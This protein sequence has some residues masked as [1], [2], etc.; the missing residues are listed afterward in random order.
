ML[1]FRLILPASVLLED[2]DGPGFVS[3]SAQDNSCSRLDIR[4]YRQRCPCFKYNNMH[5]GVL[6]RPGNWQIVEGRGPE[7]DLWKLKYYRSLRIELP[8]KSYT[9]P[10]DPKNCPLT[11]ETA[12]ICTSKNKKGSETN[13][14]HE[15]TS[16]YYYNDLIIISV[17]SHLLYSGFIKMNAKPNRIAFTPKVSTVQSSI[18][19]RG[20]LKS[21]RGFSCLYI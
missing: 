19:I 8:H 6:E 10:R 3:T 15:N 4:T 11:W 21:Q 14:G 1:S 7:A 18:L 2:I 9:V 16:Y 5:L 13:G 20:K 17:M 12:Q